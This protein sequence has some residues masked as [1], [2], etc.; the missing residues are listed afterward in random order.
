MDTPLF[1]DILKRM[2]DLIY[3]FESLRDEINN[4]LKTLSVNSK[5]DIKKWLYNNSAIT[6]LKVMK[7]YILTEGNHIVN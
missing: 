3:E 4:I 1:L 7:L 2:V 5:A 6:N